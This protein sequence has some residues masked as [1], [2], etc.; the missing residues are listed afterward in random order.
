MHHI[1]TFKA[2][3]RHGGASSEFGEW[4]MTQSL[5]LWIVFHTFWWSIL[6]KK[7]VSKP[8][9]IWYLENNHI[10]RV[11]WFVLP[12]SWGS[13]TIWIR[14]PWIAPL[15]WRENCWFA[16]FAW[17]LLQIASSS[18][19]SFGRRS[20]PFCGRRRWGTFSFVQLQIK[21][22]LNHPSKPQPVQ[23]P[24]RQARMI[25][26]VTPSPFSTSHLVFFL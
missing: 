16:P 26:Y 3:I 4:D 23:A 14:T 21:I 17:K 2:L 7:N 12:W 1:C 20:N 24:A 11:F 8:V 9:S 18:C 10:V 6:E 15:G 22:F 5:G 13:K 19:Q 25:D